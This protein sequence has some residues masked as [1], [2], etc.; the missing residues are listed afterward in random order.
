MPWLQVLDVE[1]KNQNHKSNY[2]WTGKDNTDV[3]TL[4]YPPAPDTNKT[5]LDFKMKTP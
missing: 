1:K 3:V 2:Q 5:I 4:L